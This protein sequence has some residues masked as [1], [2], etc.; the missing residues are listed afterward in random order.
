MQAA[1]VWFE[2]PHALFFTVHHEATRGHELLDV[3]PSNDV[4]SRVGEHH[5]STRICLA[6]GSYC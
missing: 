2:P 5:M 4:R 3:M 1:W 6:C